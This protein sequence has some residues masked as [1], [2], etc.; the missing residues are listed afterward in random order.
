M[1][2]FAETP[3]EKECVK[4]PKVEKSSEIL[5]KEMFKGKFADFHD[6][7]EENQIKILNLNGT[8][9]ADNSLKMLGHALT[10]TQITTVLLANH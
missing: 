8:L 6:Y 5:I 1:K 2:R 3:L 7:L 10:G 9:M 4:K